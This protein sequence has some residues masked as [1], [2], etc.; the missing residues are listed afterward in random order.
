[1]GSTRSNIDSGGGP[2]DSISVVRPATPAS[3]RVREGA[4]DTSSA[5]L[6]RGVQPPASTVSTPRE[7]PAAT[8]PGGIQKIVHQ[9]WKTR[10]LY[11]N[12]VSLAVSRWSL[13]FTDTDPK[14]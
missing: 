4:L 1:M 11:P 2:A 14:P 5:Q 13:R 8:V 6:R 12:Q 7:A 9:T 3:S 10:E